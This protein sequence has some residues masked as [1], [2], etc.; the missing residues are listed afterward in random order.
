MVTEG[1]VLGHKI[2][3]AGLEVDQAKVSI[4]ETLLPPTTVKGIR[5][6]LGH[7]GFYRIF[8]NDFSKISR[9][10][11]RLLEKYAKFDFDELCK[12]AFD[13]IKSRLVTTPIM[14][15]PDWNK[16]FYIMCDASDYAMGV[17]L[18]QRPENIFKAIYYAN[19]TFNEAQGNY[20]TTEK[21]MLAIMFACEK[22]K[23]YILRGRKK[24]SKQ[25]KQK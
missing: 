21:D 7:A 10:L 1:I 20:S 2:S 6:F 13:E 23:P 3:T 8:I 9:P 17:V 15:T 25:L 11:C 16:E 4:I 18:G 24:R 12:A 22:F 5:S 19:K 14:V